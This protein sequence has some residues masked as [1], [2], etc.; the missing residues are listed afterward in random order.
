VVNVNKSIKQNIP[1]ALLFTLL[2]LVVM[3]GV[4]FKQSLSLHNHVFIHIALQI[5]GVVVCVSI[6]LYG[7]KTFYDTTSKTFLWLSFIFIGIGILDFF[8]FIT[9]L[10]MPFF[11]SDRLLEV[12]AWFWIAARS[13]TSIGLVYLS[14]SEDRKTSVK[15]K[16]ILTFFFYL[17]AMIAIIYLIN[18]DIPKLMMNNRDPSNIAIGYFNSF[19]ILLGIMIFYKKYQQT[20]LTSELKLVVASILLLLSEIS[21]TINHDISI[22][23]VVIGYLARLFGYIYI[24]KAYFFS[25]LNVTHLQ[26][27]VEEKHMQGLIQSFFEHT[28]D[29][30]TILDTNGR[31]LAVNAGFEKMYGWKEDEVKGRM[32]R[33]LMPGSEGDIDNIVQEVAFGKSFIAY[34]ATRQRKDG[35]EITINMTV[36]PIKNKFGKIVQIAT[37][38]RDI[39][40]QREAEKKLLK[41][42]LE[43]KD[44]VRR[45][46]GIIFK[47]KKQSNRFIHTL[48]DGQ[49]LYELNSLPEQ[50]INK[51]LS[52]F[53]SE[54][55]SEFM[56]DYYEQAWQGN[57]ITF[58]VVLR[59]RICAITLRPIKREEEV[60]EVIGSCMDITQLKRTEE[61]LQKSEKLAV[62][63][64]LAAGLAH[65]IRN[66]LTTLKGFTQLIES[67]NG[68]AN[69]TYIDLML[70]ELERI[71]MITNEFMA[72]AKPQAIKFQEHDLIELTKQVV[73]FSAAQALLKN[74]DI[75]ERFDDIKATLICEGNQIKQVLINLIK[76]AIEAMPNG[77]KLEICVEQVE[78]NL[79]IK[80]KDSGI[81]IPKEI[82]PKLGEPFYTLKEK[83][84]GLGLMV[85]FRI[86]ESHKGTI[87]F[88]SEE[89]EG[90]TV[91]ITLPYKITPRE[92]S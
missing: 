49:L 43:L 22:F 10:R 47:F 34:E 52:E 17:I 27:Q 80:I 63:G 61:L 84:T 58:E 6:S 13:T 56:R 48:C 79:Q 81:G 57:D 12:S 1:V 5:I 8:Y 23:Y 89:N 30:I 71:E 59:E 42:E 87:S 44:T 64:E 51:D 90:T 72:V 74:V 11:L 37:I 26:K 36:S 76:N 41:K 31:V 78:N 2:I 66:P 16:S 65:E 29:S 68:H 67:Q 91:I 75:I 9:Y 15:K 85:S 20:K 25:K 39:T 77:G 33:D 92:Y 38:S 60:I 7:L 14:L 46:Q 4:F 35:R 21:L 3:S 83:G 24:L 19:L 73:S 62:V 86:I 40:G 53:L 50:I 45:Q 55:D 69:K 70:S 28:H 18:K 54:Q 88:E 82:L 32:V